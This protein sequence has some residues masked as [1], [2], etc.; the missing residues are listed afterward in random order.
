MNPTPTRTRSVVTRLIIGLAAGALV[1]TAAPAHAAP[2]YT[3]KVAKTPRGPAATVPL[4]HGNTLRDGAVKIT[5]PGAVVRLIGSS[6]D[7]YIVGTADDQGKDERLWRYAQDGSRTLLLR[8][9]S[10]FEAVV[11]DDG[12]TVVVAR[13][14]GRNS[15]VLVMD[16]A[17]GDR[18]AKRRLAGWV[19]A[20]DV[21]GDRVALGRWNKPGTLIWRTDTDRLRR[22]SRL[23]GYAA[24]LGRGRFAAYTGDPYDGGCSVVRTF[25][26]GS[27]RVWR[28]CADRVAEFA[29]GGR[30][31]A[32]ID[33]LSDGIGPRQVT[34]RGSHGRTKATFDI[35]GWFGLMTFEPDGSLLME[36]S[37]LKKVAT[38]RATPSGVERVTRLRPAE[39][40]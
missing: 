23:V 9:R 28:S 2:D 15:T 3:V 1:A 30:R 17:T 38:V 29:Q 4:I 8:N 19:S 34:L 24:D 33:L 11:S 7:T 22:V 5:I 13:A 36:A 40:L 27:K 21:E 32:T 39:W 6:A 37:G 20:L 26:K 25:G 18:I 12:S 35:R 10:I 31:M 14:G 16:A